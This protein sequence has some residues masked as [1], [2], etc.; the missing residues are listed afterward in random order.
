MTHGSRSNGLLHIL[1]LNSARDLFKYKSFFL[2]VYG[3]FPLVRQEF[4]QYFG[5]EEGWRGKEKGSR[6]RTLC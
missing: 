3:S 1:L 5:K 4:R 2:H 6:E